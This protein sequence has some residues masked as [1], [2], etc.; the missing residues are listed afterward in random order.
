LLRVKNDIAKI[1]SELISLLDQI[2]VESSRTIPLT[3]RMTRLLSLAIR[4]LFAIKPAPTLCDLVA[5][6]EANTYPLRDRMGMNEMRHDFLV[7]YEGI[8]DRL[9]RMLLHPKMRRIICERQYQYLDFNKVLDDGYILIISLAQLEPFLARMVGALLFQGLQST[10]FERSETEAKECAIYVDEFQD[11]IRSQYSAEM[12][13]KIFQQGRRHKVSFTIAH[14]DFSYL[15]TD[16]LNAVHSNPATLAAFACG[17]IEASKMARIFG[18]PETWNT[19]LKQDDYKMRV[20]IGNE[21]QTVETYPPPK[22]KRPLPET[23]Y[24]KPDPPDP[25]DLSTGHYGEKVADARMEVNDPRIDLADIAR[26]VRKKN[27]RDRHNQ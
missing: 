17:D 3:A 8:R 11:Y 18:E 27:T 26:G 23:K 13:R 16:F 9:S 6:L 1:E 10:I 7:S 22:P 15:D 4:S 19:I 21:V 14:L 20:R 12:F 24:D 2:V 25:F 5:Y